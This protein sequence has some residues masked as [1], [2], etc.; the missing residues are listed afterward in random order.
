[1][2]TVFFNDLGREHAVTFDYDADVVD[3]LKTV[4]KKAALPFPSR[5][6]VLLMAS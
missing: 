6:A 1:M 4:P 2:T 5:S 3:L